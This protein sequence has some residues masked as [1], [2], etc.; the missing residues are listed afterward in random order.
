MTENEK[1]E[2]RSE[3]MRSEANLIKLSVTSYDSLVTIHK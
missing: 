2:V 1:W 3:A